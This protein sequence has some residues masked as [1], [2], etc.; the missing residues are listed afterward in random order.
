[1]AITTA[2]NL[3][4]TLNRVRLL[5]PAQLDELSRGLAGR[6]ADPLVLARELMQRGWLTPYQINQLFQGNGGDLMLGHYLLLE[7]LGEGGMGQVFK[8][9]EQRLGRIVALKVLRK[10]CVVK[11]DVLRRF[12][13]EIQA[14][15]RLSHPNIVHA[16]DAEQIGD[17]HVFAMEYVEGIDLSRLVKQS[18]RLA[19]AQACEYVRQTAVGLQHLHNIGMVHRDIKP[20]N[21]MR[22]APGGTI[23][24]LDLGLARLLDEESSERTVLKLTRLGVV[25][26]TLDYLAPEQALNSHRADIR[27]DLYSLGCTFYFLLTGR[28]PFPVE[29]PMA[30]LLAHSCD[31]P[32]PV[33]QVRPDV[34][35][36]VAAIVRKLMGRHP[37]DR[38]QTPA[39]LVQALATPTPSPT[40]IATPPPAQPVAPLAAPA[41]APPLAVPVAQRRRTRSARR[42]KIWLAAA[43]VIL[44]PLLIGLLVHFLRGDKPPAPAGGPVDSRRRAADGSKITN[45]LKMELIRINPGK[46]FMGAP[47]KEPTHR[48]DETPER[49]VT[50][51]RPFYLGANLVTVGNFNEFVEKTDYKTEAEQDNDTRPG[52]YWRK[53]GWPQTDKHPVACLSW[54]DAQAFCEWLTKKEK[55]T[56]RLPTE[57]EW[58]Y[59]CRAESNAA[60]SFGS[61]PKK[62]DDYAWHRGN[63][64]GRA[65]PVGERR[66]NRWG[67]HDMHG[68]LLQ[69][70]G[71]YYDARFYQKIVLEDPQGPARGWQRVLR[72]GFW[73]SFPRDCRSARRFTAAADR[74]GNDS[75]F[76]VVLV[77]P[78]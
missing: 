39:E 49:E 7:R 60:Y 54:N 66:P 61:D 4:E 65:H 56:Y 24:I 29:E 63:S 34:P 77:L 42:G 75:G 15:A 3:I 62:L 71:D 31:K 22:A 73:D 27:S 43:A 78:E 45:S 50:I 70:C 20:A 6:P 23:K 67:L 2:R 41:V 44:A 32:D 52:R 11:P 55:R 28:V 46:F 35:A 51:T 16:Y 48:P 37:E 21:L 64:G 76:R 17:T 25:M 33:E 74:H 10:E 36:N 1:M 68:N 9:R 69:W 14:A 30:K 38:Y 18:G 47:T 57:A 13:H 12:H 58:E 8:A 72:G 59:A 53:P 40:A 26:G 19:M 5:E